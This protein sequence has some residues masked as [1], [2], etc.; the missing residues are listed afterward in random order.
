MN[1]L[2]NLGFF[3][4]FLLYFLIYINPGKINYKLGDQRLHYHHSMDLTSVKKVSV[5][6][7]AIVAP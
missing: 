5:Q 6:D 7:T 2:G 3:E 4:A 1:R